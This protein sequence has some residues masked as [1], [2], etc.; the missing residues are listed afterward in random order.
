MHGQTE[1]LKQ[2]LEEMLASDDMEWVKAAQV[3]VNA[4]YT[5][6]QREQQDSRQIV[7]L[8]TRALSRPHVALSCKWRPHD[9]LGL[10]VT[11]VV[12]LLVL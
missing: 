3:T 12:V 6:F 11:M 10:G 7:P 5:Q 1:Q 4:M 8:G 2:K 9:G